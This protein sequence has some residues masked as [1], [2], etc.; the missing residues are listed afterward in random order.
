MVGRVGRGRIGCGDEQ[1]ALRRLDTGVHALVGLEK[2]WEGAVG[3]L[4]DK[5]VESCIHYSWKICAGLGCTIKPSLT[6]HILLSML[7][8]MIK[9]L[10]LFALSRSTIAARC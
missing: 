2:G 1:V 5:M 8:G 10:K 3:P 7:N 9:P 4:L 6:H